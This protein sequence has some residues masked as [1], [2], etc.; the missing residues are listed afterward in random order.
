MINIDAGIQRKMEK[1][2]RGCKAIRQIGR[3]GGMICCAALVI[4]IVLCIMGKVEVAL[5]FAMGIGLFI[6][7]AA[8]LAIP[9]EVQQALQL[10]YE[11][12]YK[13]RVAEPVLRSCFDT[14]R[15]SP[16]EGFSKREFI[17]S[18]VMAAANNMKFY[19]AEDLL[20]GEYEGVTFCQSDVKIRIL[21]VPVYVPLQYDAVNKKYVHASQPR[22]TEKQQYSHK[23][24]T[25]NGRLLKL[26]YKKSIQGKIRIISK[27]FKYRSGTEDI[28]LVIGDLDN[29]MAAGSYTGGISSTAMED[30][31]FNKRFKVYAT[32]I[33]SAFYLLTPPVMEYFKQLYDIDRQLAISF[34][35]ES[36]YIYRS[37]KGGVFEPSIEYPFQVSLEEERCRKEVE[38]IMKCIEVLRLD[39]KQEFENA[40]QEAF[41]KE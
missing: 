6:A 1:L 18:G 21:D 13:Q 38:E 3:V 24:I 12:L 19:H 9:S 20:E 34:D 22:N 37:Q 15:Y 33:H 29:F 40:L 32:D 11:K 41:D 30:V 26:Q 7:M 14:I 4:L 5:T 23:E 10:K 2:R 39:E 28:P 36:L 16:T 8:V 25:L 35:G 27:D 31:E 17:D